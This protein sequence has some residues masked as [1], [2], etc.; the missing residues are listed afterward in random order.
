[1]SSVSA[2]GGGTAAMSQS[3]YQSKAVDSKKA[4]E[5]FAKLD[6]NGDNS[7]D[8][9]EMKA[10]TDFVAKKTGATGLDPDALMK[11]L[12]SDGDGSVSSTELASNAKSLFQ[13]LRAQLVSSQPSSSTTQPTDADKLFAALDSNGDGS[14]SSDEFKAGL[15]RGPGGAHSGGHHGS[16]HMLANLIQEYGTESSGATASSS[17]VSVAA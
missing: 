11:S 4:Q 12:D 10:F 15:Q 6:V 2:C 8:S 7:I 9:S 17:T 16:G 13:T 3:L 1:M 14:I 5:L